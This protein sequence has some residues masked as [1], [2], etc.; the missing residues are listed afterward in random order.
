MPH[1]E[2]LHHIGGSSRKQISKNG[3]DPGGREPGTGGDRDTGGPLIEEIYA[4]GS[5]TSRRAA[6]RASYR[7]QRSVFYFFWKNYRRTFRVLLIPF[8][9]PILGLRFIIA[10]LKSL[11]KR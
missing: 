1:S 7:M 3:K 5:R 2:V 4:S 10:L 6:I 11:L 8:I 9:I